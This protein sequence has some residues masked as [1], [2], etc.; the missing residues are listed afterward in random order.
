MTQSSSDLLV[1]PVH[2]VPDAAYG[3]S[4]LARRLREAM[5]GDIFFDA[6]SRGRYA[7]DASIYQIMPVGVVVPRD[8]D[9]L[10]IAL[11]VARSERAAVLARGAGTSQ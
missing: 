8:Q 7:T 6:A 11:D 3:G 10:R 9:D 5:R 1:K 2:L 4:P